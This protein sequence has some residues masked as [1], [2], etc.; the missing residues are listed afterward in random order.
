MFQ[1]PKKQKKEREKFYSVY[2]ASMHLGLCY[3]SVWDACQRWVQ[4]EGKKRRSGLPHERLQ[5]GDGKD[6]YLIYESD[7]LNW[8]DKSLAYLQTQKNKIRIREQKMGI[9]A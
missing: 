1:L 3:Q 2:T 5:I 9:S 4:S 8:R 7:L 6:T